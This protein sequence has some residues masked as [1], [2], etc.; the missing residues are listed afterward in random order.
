MQS[1]RVSSIPN[2]KKYFAEFKEGNERGLEFFYKRLYS[3]IYYY[4]FRY[5]KDDISA[6]CIVSEAFLRLWLCRQ[7]ITC[8]EHIETFLT[9]VTAEGCRAY[10]KTNAN[11]FQRNMLRLDEIEN[12]QE[13]K[14]GYNPDSDWEENVIYHHEPL[15]EEKKQWERI[16]AVL[17]NL[18][19]DQQLFIRLCI[20]YSFDYPRMAWHIGGISDYQVARKVE[21]TLEYLKAVISDAENF[22]KLEKTTKFS[23]E[24][25]VSEEESKILNMRYELQYSFSQIAVALNLD[26]GYIQRA[27]AAASLRITKSRKR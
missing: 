16:E 24:G 3:S 27:F 21:R 9:K 10:Y 6:D 17:P 1:T 19:P 26:Q 15:D 13:F 25:E 11:S 20:K 8:I 14:V 2:Q 23:F 4:S 18:S 5:I 22:N 12:Y 7:N